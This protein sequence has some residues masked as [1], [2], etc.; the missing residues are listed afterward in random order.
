MKPKTIKI[1]LIIHLFA[2]AHSLMVIVFLYWLEWNDEIVLTILTIMMVFWITRL[3]G[4]PIDV[5]AVLTLLSTLAGYYIGTQGA[6]WMAGNNLFV[7]PYSNIVMT[8]IATEFLGWTTF[9]I[10]RRT[11]IQKKTNI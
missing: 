8:F 10:I 5:G 11:Q 1:N 6:E 4:V 7:A 2:L 9:F 3:Y